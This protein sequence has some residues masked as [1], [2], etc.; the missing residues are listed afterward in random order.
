MQ[1]RLGHI[2]E[3]KNLFQLVVGLPIGIFLSEV[4]A[5]IIVYYI[6]VDYS[7]TILIDAVVTTSLMLP[8]I[9]IL[10]YRPLLRNIA[11]REQSDRIIDFRLRVMQYSISHSLDE[12]LQ[13]TL[14][15]IQLLTGGTIGFFHFVLDDQ[16]T[17]WLQAWS[18]NTIQNMCSAEGKHSHYNLSE[19]G[20]WADCVRLRRPVVHND[21]ASVEGRKGTPE[22]HAP[23]L[24]EMSVPIFR[25]EQVVAIMGIGNKPSNFTQ[26]DVELVSTL[27]DFSWDIIERKRAEDTLRESEEKFRT[28]VDWTYDWE[29]WVDEEGQ[30]VYISPS[31][32]NSSG[33]RPEEFI[34]DPDLSHRI[35][36]EDD[37]DLFEEHRQLIHDQTAGVSNIEYRIIARDGS[38][39]WIDHICRPLFDKEGQFL[40][41]R[42]SN[43]DITLRK[44]AENEIIERI[45]RENRLAQAIQNIQLDLARDLHD[46]VG[47]NIGYL[48]MRLDHLNETNLQTRLD[49]ES[50]IAR[51]LKVANESYD[52]VR[53]NLD[54][55]QSAS[56]DHPL[57]LLTQY[58][59]QVE[60]RSFLKI[61]IS[62]RG[63]PKPLY[64]TQIRQIFFVFREALNNIEKHAG[65]SKVTVT[66]NW[67]EDKLSMVIEDDG[68]GFNPEESLNGNHYGL[69]FMKERMT[70]LEGDFS[71]QS[72][73]DKGTKIKISLP[74]SYG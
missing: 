23:I 72:K 43:R 71:I 53:G 19:A 45:K 24:R 62:T 14:D 29:L 47:Q 28:L 22:G 63:N 4:I 27:A 65:A 39:H 10:S 41:R 68:H 30:Y 57:P 73:I 54:L 49:L 11:K 55:L 44:L 3:S 26:K 64:P 13:F 56:I 20:V 6:E 50:E 48:R 69:K 66:L 61:K 36:H 21:F 12:L 34:A 2:F 60:E 33:Y 7:L 70:S 40:G 1:E 25:N 31:C 16:E 51:M 9:Y 46:T 32:E 59:D 5:M 42:V 18:T 52:L 8:L 74:L 15:E 38:V 35:I 67:L 17:L 58:A 37:C